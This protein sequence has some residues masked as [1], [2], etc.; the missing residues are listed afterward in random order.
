MLSLLLLL[1]ALLLGAFAYWGL[2]T[3]AGAA[4]FDEM[5]GMI[6]V[7]AAAAAALLLLAAALAWWLARR[8]GA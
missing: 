6:P 5:A 2:Y 3:R 4:R 8:G 7:A 1:L